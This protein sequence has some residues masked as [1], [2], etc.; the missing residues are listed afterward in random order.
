MRPDDLTVE[1]RDKNLQR[2]GKVLSRDLDLKA[3]LRWCGV[4]E[5]TLTLPGDHTMVPH[6]LTPGSGL[7]V[8]GPTG[9]ASRGVIFSGPTTL[10]KR[11]RDQKNPDGTLTFTGV[12]DEVHL[13]DALAFPDPTVSANPAMQTKTNDIRTGTTENLFRQYV[14]Y[15]VTYDQALAGRVRGFRNFIDLGTSLGGLGVTQTKAPRFQNLLELLQEIAVY[16]GGYG[17]RLQQKDD[18]LV[19]DTI[20]VRDLRATIRLDMSNGTLT[21][22][23]IASQGATVTTAIVAGQGEGIERQMIQR[24]DLTDEATWSRVIEKFFDRRDTADVTILE[25]KGDE[26][27]S[28]GSGGTSAKIIPAD[29]QTMRYPVD[30]REGDWITVVVDGQE[31]DSVVTEAILLVNSTTCRVGVAIGDVSTYDPRDQETKNQQTIDSRVG[32]LERNLSAGWLAGDIK[33]TARTTAPEGWLMCDGTVK[34]RADYPVLFQAIGTTY[35]TGGETGAQFR[36][37]SRQGRVGVGR[38]AT[39]AEF[40]T[41]G[42]TGGAKTHTLSVA[43]MPSHTHTQ[44]A[45]GHGVNGTGNAFVANGGGGATANVS[46]GGGG[47]TLVG[48]ANATATN[49]NT[50][51]G[52]AHNNLQPYVVLNYLIKT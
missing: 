13:D 10:P 16:D 38:D 27:L 44:N 17:F 11:K 24:Q 52:G 32:Y 29:D 48:V 20:P 12:T 19:F 35:N 51:G 25:Q 7:V 2:Q 42:E 14:A 9:G 46:T 18:L 30:W 33:E 37:P 34:N 47:Y 40:D 36:L 31:R 41:L 4:G 50:G 15:N 22:E 21:S 43:E 8:T 49:Q 1:V 5:W 26:E 3:K 6:L 28:A 39:Q 45:H 23:E